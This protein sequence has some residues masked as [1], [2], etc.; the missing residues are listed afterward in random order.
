MRP[1]LEIVQPSAVRVTEMSSL[2]TRSARMKTMKVDAGAV[3]EGCSA[4]TPPPAAITAV[5]RTLPRAAALIWR[6]RMQRIKCRAGMTTEHSTTTYELVRRHAGQFNRDDVGRLVVSGTDRASYLNGLLTNDIAALGAG[7]GCYA[8]YLTA[9]GRMITDLH[10][11]ELGDVILLTL[12]RDVKNAVLAKLDQFIFSEDVQV[13]D[14]TDS[15]ADVA[16]IGPDAAGIAGGVLADIT[17]G[18]LAALLEHGNVRAGFA[19]QSV[20]VL[21]VTDTGEPGFEML[22]DAAAAGALTSALGAAGAV[23]VDAGLVEVLRVEAGVPKFHRDMDEDTIPLEAG[24]EPRAIS[25]TK[26][27]YVGQEVIIRVLHRGH[28]RVARRL[29]G[30]TLDGAVVPTPGAP[31]HAQ[32]REIGQVTSAVASPALSSP[33]ALAYLHRD[34]TEVGTRVT[35]N[36]ADGVVTALPFVR[37]R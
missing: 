21:R 37:G 29:V 8:A 24:I 2:P 34:F 16:L 13:G 32:G 14:V 33:I 36:G 17:P 6:T 19:G 22:I 35:V 25:M 11:Y 26:G 18:A 31:V 10:V 9:Q 20:I 12:P 28:G 27:C 3:D 4:E 23:S 5:A 1:A 15:F 30:L 7:Q